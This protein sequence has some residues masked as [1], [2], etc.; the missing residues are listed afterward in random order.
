MTVNT[1]DIA[2]VGRAIYN[3][4]IRNLV[5]PARKPTMVLID[6]NSG[7]YEISGDDATALATL[8]ERHPDA[9]VW[10]ELVG[11][12]EAPPIDFKRPRYVDPETLAELVEIIKREYPQYD[13]G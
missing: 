2:A 13:Q 10:A 7:D 3:E 11:Y 4:K 6:V 5:E 8:K 12:P 1:D 9:V